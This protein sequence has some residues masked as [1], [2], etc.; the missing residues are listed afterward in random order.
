MG[1]CSPFA[2]CIYRSSTGTTG[3]SG[4]TITPSARTEC[5]KLRLL[6]F[7]IGSPTPT[8]PAESVARSR[9]YFSVLINTSDDGQ[10]P[11][12]PARRDAYKNS[13]HRALVKWSLLTRIVVTLLYSVLW[14]K[15]RGRAMQYWIEIPYVAIALAILFRKACGSFRFVAGSAL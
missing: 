10:T 7:P 1:L 8:I 14:R 13:S 15:W 4:L 2:S 5:N 9:L 6:I 11:S 12:E 3:V